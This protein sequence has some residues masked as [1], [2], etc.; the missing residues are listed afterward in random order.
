MPA[1]KHACTCTRTF[2]R[3]YAWLI[4]WIHAP[5]HGCDVC[6][7][8]RG[9]KC[10]PPV[11]AYMRTCTSTVHAR[12]RSQVG[13]HTCRRTHACMQGG[14]RAQACTQNHAHTRHVCTHAH[15]FA[16]LGSHL[17]S[18]T[19]G[20][21]RGIYLA[22]YR[23]MARVSIESHLVLQVVGPHNSLRSLSTVGHAC[24]HTQRHITLQA[25]THAHVRAHI[26]TC[27]CATVSL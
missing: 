19:A 5:T 18:L 11:Q 8:E 20:H 12:A 10:A 1:C 6:A 4:R 7:L 13:R 17:V 24:A 22:G 3:T 15:V 16:G 14:M 26:F 9:H 27:T 21:G 25:F 2:T 23:A